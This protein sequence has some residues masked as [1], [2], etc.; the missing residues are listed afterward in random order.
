MAPS[1]SRSR[2]ADVMERTRVSLALRERLGAAGGAGLQEFVDHELIRV[3]ERVLNLAVE[4]FERRLVTEAAGLR[5]E[6]TTKMMDG[7]SAIRQ[8][9]AT[10]RVEALRWSFL[11]WVGQVAAMVGLFTILLRVLKP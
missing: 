10:N 8:E 7:F 6:L 3:E 1:S 5:V 11:F 2:K 4:R 9:L